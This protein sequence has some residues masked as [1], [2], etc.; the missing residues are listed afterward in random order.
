MVIMFWSLGRFYIGILLPDE[1]SFSISL[2][3]DKYKL[4]LAEIMS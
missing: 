3:L 2:H 4:I 1:N